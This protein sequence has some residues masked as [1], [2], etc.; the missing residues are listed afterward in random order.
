MTGAALTI[1][2]GQVKYILGYKINMGSSTRWPDYL[3]QYIQNM[4]QLRWQEYIMGV[5]CIFIQI[6]F[7]VNA[8]QATLTYL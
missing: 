6:F 1:G 8:S 3:Q 5:M 2:T 4:N 7:K